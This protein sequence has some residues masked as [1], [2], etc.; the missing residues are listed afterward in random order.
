MSDAVVSD[1]ITW[2]EQFYLVFFM[3]V[4]LSC[5]S[6][7][8]QIIVGK[9]TFTQTTVLSLSVFQIDNNSNDH[10]ATGIDMTHFWGDFMGLYLLMYCSWIYEP[11]IT[12]NN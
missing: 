8:F 4:S 6:D 5:E 3:A 1:H 9:I 12:Y 2:T 7:Q 11:H 10:S